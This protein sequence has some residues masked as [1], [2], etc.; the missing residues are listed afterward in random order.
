MLDQ[1]VIAAAEVNIPNPKAPI[2]GHTNQHVFYSRDCE[3]G[4]SNVIRL[5]MP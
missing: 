2:H 4:R 3:D 5:H 1:D